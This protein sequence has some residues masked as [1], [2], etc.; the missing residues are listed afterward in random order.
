MPR[1]DEWCGVSPGN[2]VVVVWFGMATVS[3]VVAV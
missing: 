2:D 3:C 1:G